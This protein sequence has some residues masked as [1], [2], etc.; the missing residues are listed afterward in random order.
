MLFQNSIWQDKKTKAWMILEYDDEGEKEL[1]SFL[2]Y[3]SDGQRT[4]RKS[5]AFFSEEDQWDSLRAFGQFML[6]Q[7]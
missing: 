4:L 2:L 1:G 3:S 6:D 7:Y 5:I